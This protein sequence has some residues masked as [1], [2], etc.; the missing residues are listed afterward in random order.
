MG[1][2]EGEVEELLG[3]Q[4][5]LLEKREYYQSEEFVEKQAR[6][7][8]NMAKEGETVVILPEGEGVLGEV[9]IS[10]ERQEPIWKKWLGVFGF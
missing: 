6:D 1:E 2:A 9:E 4:E 3:E 10:R 8:L 7:K 5:A